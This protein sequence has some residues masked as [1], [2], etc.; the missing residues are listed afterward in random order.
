MGLTSPVTPRV[1]VPNCHIHSKIVTY[2]TT[3]EKPEYLII[4]SFDPGG[5][6]GDDSL[7]LSY[8]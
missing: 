1:Q 7:Y 8:L 4:G 5:N 2:I 6:I 3:I